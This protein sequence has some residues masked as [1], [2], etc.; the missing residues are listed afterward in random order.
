MLAICADRDRW[1]EQKKS[2]YANAKIT[3]FYN[4]PR[5][6]EDEDGE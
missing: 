3:E 2:E 4:R 1:V 6:S 5:E